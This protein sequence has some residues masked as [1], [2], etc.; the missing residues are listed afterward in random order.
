M[1]KSHFERWLRIP[2]PAISHPSPRRAA[3]AREACRRPARLAVL[4]GV[5]AFCASPVATAAPA[6]ARPA[7]ASVG[8]R[9]TEPERPT[10][11]EFSSV[12]HGGQ[13]NKDHQS[14]GFSEYGLQPDG[15][16]SHGPKNYRKSQRSAGNRDRGLR[17]GGYGDASFYY[18]T[19]RQQKAAKR[20]RH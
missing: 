10:A 19:L 18:K 1:M 4:I 17:F 9:S 8:A 20:G 13:R 15:G 14:N 7:F 16:Y 3:L 6:D 2:Q 12:L 11:D 5:A